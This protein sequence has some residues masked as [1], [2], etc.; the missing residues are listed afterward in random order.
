MKAGHHLLQVDLELVH[1]SERMDTWESPLK[2][3]ENPSL[4]ALRR[5]I[6]EWTPKTSTGRS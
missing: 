1:R 3:S 5:S 4:E 6:G 2:A